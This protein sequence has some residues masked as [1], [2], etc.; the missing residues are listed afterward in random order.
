MKRDDPTKACF[1]LGK[2]S[3]NTKYPICTLAVPQAPTTPIAAIITYTL[4][5]YRIIEKAAN[6]INNPT[7]HT[8]ILP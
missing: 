6:Y 3:T 2:F 1:E 8:G 4:F 5:V 7:R